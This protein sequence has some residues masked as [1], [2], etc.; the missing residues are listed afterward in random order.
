MEVTF[1]GEV[2][3][4]ALGLVAH[5]A[6]A[7]ILS[8]VTD[9]PVNQ[10]NAP[11]IARQKGI[12]L[13]VTRA[14]EA[15]SRVPSLELRAGR[16][17]EKH[18]LSGYLTPHGQIRLLEVDG[19]P[20]DMA[21]AEHMLFDFHQD[22]PGIIGRVGTIL[23]EHGVNIAAMSVGRR[24]VGGEAVMVLAVDDPVPA[25]VLE[26]LRGIPGVHQFRAVSL[27][28]ALLELRLPQLVSR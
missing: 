19:L 17:A 1:R 10:V 6:L 3:E 14:G 11:V 22:R 24:E 7:G 21:P 16:G 2:E 18:R 9:R 27:P 13:Q 12:S 4:R 28:R 26:K 5:A 8:G 23:G 20:L 25:E 15:Q